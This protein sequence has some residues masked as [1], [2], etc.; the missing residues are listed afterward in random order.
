MAKHCEDKHWIEKATAKN[1]GKLRAEVGAKPG[2]PISGKQ[3]AHAEH[4][5]NKTVRK[6]ANL[7]AELKTF[8]HS[9]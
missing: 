7:A 8:R 4:S 2:K 9:K 6:E 3:M 1:K 5:K